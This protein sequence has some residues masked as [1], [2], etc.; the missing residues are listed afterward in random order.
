MNTRAKTTIDTNRC[1]VSCTS[2]FGDIPVIGASIF[3]VNPDIPASYILTHAA[4]L[5]RSTRDTLIYTDD[6]LDGDQVWLLWSNL[7]MLV[8][9]I[10]S[11]ELA[12]R[13]AA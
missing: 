6:G 1:K 11:L 10:D 3:K 13:D 7:D 12:V 9:L 5:A 8:A 4:C 2:E